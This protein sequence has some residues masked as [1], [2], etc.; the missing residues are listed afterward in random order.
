M[1]TKFVKVGSPR[2]IFIESKL[3]LQFDELALERAS[4]DMSALVKS[5][6]GVIEELVNMDTLQ[7]FEVS[8]M[9]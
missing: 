9:Y 7:K 5:A 8:S 6:K 2:Q 4:N 3:R 1:Y